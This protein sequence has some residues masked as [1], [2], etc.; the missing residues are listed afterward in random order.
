MTI[1]EF[2]LAVLSQFEARTSDDEVK[3]DLE[4]TCRSCD[5]VLCDIE[6]GDS[7]DVL[8]RTVADH[9]CAD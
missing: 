4:L 3:R 1:T 7:L 5:E 9:S 2:D 8:V 6:H